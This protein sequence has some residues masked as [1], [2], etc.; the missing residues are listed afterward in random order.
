[1]R[2]GTVAQRRRSCVVADQDDSSR[3]VGGVA[4]ARRGGG[5]GDVL[6]ERCE[7][8]GEWRELCDCVECSREEENRTVGAALDQWAAHIG[9]G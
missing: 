7:R 2:G 5:T 4:R 6:P 3:V 1:M 9:S 8:S